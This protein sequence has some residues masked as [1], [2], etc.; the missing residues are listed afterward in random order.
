MEPVVAAADHL[1][2]EIELGRCGNLNLGLDPGFAGS[3]HAATTSAG[4]DL[5]S[6]THSSTVSV[7]ARRMGSMSAAVSQA[8]MPAFGSCKTSAMELATCLRFWRNPELTILKKSGCS[9]IGRGG[10]SR[11]SRITTADSTLGGGMKTS[12]ETVNASRGSAK[13][14]VATLSTLISGGCGGQAFGDL[15]LQHH[16]QTPRLARLL[17]QMSQDR[18][19]HRVGEVGDDVERLARRE[20]LVGR[21]R[22]GILLDELETGDITEG[23]PQMGRQ[24]AIE[25][26]GDDAMGLAQQLRGEDPQAGTDLEHRVALGHTRLA[27][28]PLDQPAL[29]E[30]VLTETLVRANPE[31]GHETHPVPA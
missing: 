21:C 2:P 29:E 14:C 1:Q 19:P 8:A 3:V 28:H 13:N 31:V 24:R 22:Q 7:S 5:V 6:V 25:L 27:D 23:R 20:E 30:K 12:G 11:T 15:F 10:S 16:R 18:G 26:D 17:Q 4:A 9:S